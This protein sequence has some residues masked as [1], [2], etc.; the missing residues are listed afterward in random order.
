MKKALNNV[1]WAALGGLGLMLAFAFQAPYVAYFMYAFL[2]LVALA[3]ITTRLWL[4][5]IAW[6]EQNPGKG[7]AAAQSAPEFFVL[8]LTSALGMTLMVGTL[9]L[10]VII[11]AIEMASLPSYAIVG[12]DKRS[13]PGA[14]GISRHCASGCASPCAVSRRAGPARN[15]SS[16]CSSSTYSAGR[17]MGGA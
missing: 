17:V 16:T 5:G 2:L 1:L 4:T 10:L 13:R 15:R 12:S 9:N 14:I 6:R 3:N 11:I 8:L 7:R